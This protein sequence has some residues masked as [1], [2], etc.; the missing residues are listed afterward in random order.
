MRSVLDR[1]SFWSIRGGFVRSV[2][3]LL[4]ERWCSSARE[5]GTWGIYSSSR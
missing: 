2:V 1:G 5:K 4:T 3:V